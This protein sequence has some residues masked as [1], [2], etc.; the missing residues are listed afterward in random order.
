MA[1]FNIGELNMG[2]FSWFSK[3]R[4]IRKQRLKHKPS[5]VKRRLELESL[6][7]RCVPTTIPV[8]TAS[9]P[10]VTPTTVTQTLTF[11]ATQPTTLYGDFAQFNSSLGTLESITITQNGT[12]SSDIQVE[13]LSAT[14]TANI[15]ATVQGTLGLSLTQSGNPI[16][17][18]S[19]DALAGTYLAAANPSFNP[20]NPV[21]SFAN[22]TGTNFGAQYP[23]GYESASGQGST[24]LTGAAL[25]SFIGS[26]MV[27]L[28]ET[29][30]AASNATSE[31][32]N[33]G[34]NGGN[35]DVYIQSTATDT[36]TV[37]Y[38]YVPSAD[39]S[40][41]KTA[42]PT[43]APVG[44]N[45]TYT[46]VV[47]NNGPNT[48]NGVVA[49]DPLPAGTTF[50]GASGTNWTF[51]SSI[52]NN[53]DTITAD[54]APSLV[55]QA[56]STFTITATMPSAPGPV[57]N[58]ATVSSATPD[59]NLSN[60]ISSA[61]V[62]VYEPTDMTI[63]KTASPNPV[64]TNGTLTY[65]LTA[66]NDGPGPASQVSVT[67]PLPAGTSYVGASGT[68]W[69]FTS[70]IVNNVDTITANLGTTLA[71]NTTSTFYI[72]VTAPSTPGTITNTATVATT[73]PETN[74]SNNIA[75][76]QT[77]VIQPADVSIVKT[78]NPN[79]VEVGNDLTYT[80]TVGNAGPA[81]ANNVVVTDPLPA[82]T[83][84]VSEAGS[85]WS[86]SSSTVN[87]VM[88][89]TADLTGSLAVNGSSFFT[90][91]V[92]APSTPGMI[93]NTATVT[94]STPDINLGNNTSTVTTQVV[95]TADLAI[96]KTAP[97]TVQ[98]GSTLTYTLTVSNLV[99]ATANQVVV[100]DPLPS[101]E[102]FIS[103]IGPGWTITEN[104]INN[105]YVVTATDA[106]PLPVG[107]STFFTIAVQAPLFA[108][109][110][111]NTATVTS[112]TPDNNLS[113]N[114]ASATTII[115]NPPGTLYTQNLPQVKF[116]SIPI[117]SK[118]QLMGGSLPVGT[119]TLASQI[120][121][122]YLTLTG[123][124]PGAA[125]VS[126]IL[127]EIQTGKTSMQ[128][129]AGQLWVST[130]HLTQEVTTAYQTFLDRNPTTSE[131]NAGISL[132][133]S[134]GS[135]LTLATNLLTSPEFAQDNQ[136]SLSM[137]AALSADV[138]GVVPS[139]SSLMLTASSLG[140]STQS[141]GTNTFSAAT[142]AAY[143]QQTLS[144]PQALT[145]LVTNT[146]LGIFGQPPTAAQ[147]QTWTTE[148]A[149]NQ[150]TPDQ[151]MQQLLASSA[152][153]LLAYQHSH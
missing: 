86:F 48:A 3:D 96:T 131:L 64:L 24:S 11:P 16:S 91:T 23:S 74:Y 150:V 7:D 83:T 33:N 101:G 81:I 102:T 43:S 118:V 95:Q 62:S 55:N 32:D 58:T 104:T 44:S 153:G 51:T 135:E 151:F 98:V 41:V 18:V 109:V 146:Y 40:I 73:T 128:A 63:T 72:T 117:M 5:E 76:V 97:A 92:Q 20:A 67:D 35:I 126:N 70:S 123:Q 25:A 45:V 54:L 65:T 19:P 28:T 69:T 129:L 119:A 89:I 4:T 120:V 114:T 110:V 66:I 88:T 57:T 1:V 148:L 124:N 49:T 52:V 10:V 38:N 77:Q 12:I 50:V 121:S 82:N 105:N 107:V 137:L 134:G 79:P 21:F 61:I 140:V 34:S 127:T 113:N 2:I 84:F 80:I 31:T 125:T 143:V 139:L 106:S 149:N 94:S 144:S 9:T 145:S 138:L 8:Y 100:T 29:D 71:A 108:T 30:Q 15:T 99:G 85:G 130:Q 142:W 147:L 112:A 141:L 136:G 37:T 111:T 39:L 42:S 17:S 56:T 103:G 13:N 132:L 47:T 68:G 46:M 22:P 27:S 90:I 93:T 6:E 133:K 75:T 14:S 53:V 116:G 87:N 152:F 59:P 60:N 122:L 115:T 36:V 26:G 78:A